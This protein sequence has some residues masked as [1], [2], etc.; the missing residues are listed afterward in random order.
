VSLA[1]V[2]HSEAQARAPLLRQDAWPLRTQGRFIV[3]RLGERVK[4]ACVNW[5]GPESNTYAVGG[6]EVRPI[7]AIAQRIVDLGFNCVRFPYTL[8]AHIKNPPVAPEF[9]TANPQLKGKHFLEVFDAAIAAAT[10]AGLMVIIDNHMSKSGWCC[11]WSQ[12][13]GLWYH[14]YGEKGWIDSIVNMTK[15]YKENPLVVAFDIRN[16]IHDWHGPNATGMQGVEKMLTWGDGNPD[17]DWGAAA[18]RA[19]NKVLEANPNMLIVVMG[20][21][22]GM[23]LRP[24]R[25]HPI[26]LNLPNRVIYQTHNYV[27]YQFWQLLQRN[28]ITFKTISHIC[29][30]AIFLCVSILGMLVTSWKKHGYA[31]P[32]TGILLLSI[33][34][35]LTGF[36]LVFVVVAQIAFKAGCVYCKWGALIDVLQYTYYALAVTFCGLLA[37]AFGL[38]Q[39]FAGPPLEDDSREVQALDVSEDS[40]EPD[41]PAFWSLAQAL[42]NHKNMQKP[43]WNKHLTRGLQASILCT[44]LLA[45]FAVVFAVARM[46]DTYEFYRDWMDHMWGFVLEEGQPYTAPV[47]MGEFGYLNDGVYWLNFMRYLADRD[48]DFAYW[49]INGKK[50]ASGFISPDGAWHQYPQGKWVSEL[51]GLLEADWSTIKLAWRI[52][53]LQALMASPATWRVTDIGCKTDFLGHFCQLIY[54]PPQ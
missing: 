28:F 36:G 7:D 50:Y 42:S 51:F 2:T 19:G 8:E 13:E 17:T 24:V 16:E 39:V 5:Y 15:R 47:W 27:E 4:W 44:V 22:F 43:R 1:T 20:F 46:V 9:L 29:L 21:C 45:V 18:T 14:I 30:F 37:A 49:A 25:D 40:T 11:H 12:K 54:D 35:W 34:S 6:L 3:D 23:E 26:M 31:R 38:L 48:V 52:R 33:G 53:G 41:P 32:P 10:G